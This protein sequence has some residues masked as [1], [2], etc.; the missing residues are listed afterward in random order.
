MVKNFFKNGRDF[1]TSRQTSILSAAFAIMV[2]TLLSKILGLVKDRVLTTYFPSPGLELDVYFAASKF[3]EALLLVFV[4]GAISTAFV[5]VFTDYLREKRLVAWEMAFSAMTAV[6]FLFSVLVV[7][8]IIVAPF[9]P[10]IL[11]PGLSGKNDAYVLMVR[12]LRLMFVS[13]IVFVASGFL[14]GVLHSFRRFVIPALAPVFYN[15]GVIGGIVFLSGRLGIDAAAWGML[16]GAVFHFLVQLP[17][18]ILIFKARRR[19]NLKLGFWHPGIMRVAKMSLPR[20]LGVLFAQTNDIVSLAL[21]SLVSLGA[22]TS[23]S[24]GGHLALAPVSLFGA[25]IGQATLPTLSSAVS[26]GKIRVFA[27]TLMVSL[28]QIIFL[29][30]GASVV[31]AVLKVPLVRLVFGASRFDW[32]ATVE[33]ARVV[34]GF[35]VGLFARAAVELLNRGFYAFEDSLTPLKVNIGSALVNIFLSGVLVLG[36]GLP[37]WGLAIAF[38]TAA[39]LNFLVIFWWLHQKV[40]FDLFR[41]GEFC[42][43]V[44]IASSLAG[45]SIYIPLKLLDKLVID[46]TRVVGLILLTGVVGTIGFSVYVFLTWLLKIEEAYMILRVFEKVRVSWKKLSAMPESAVAPPVSSEGQHLG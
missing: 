35:S 30:A 43:K 26:S 16:L 2:L 27:K 40:G 46:T 8:L 28:K 29:V 37:V 3:P 1:L 33:T 5:P 24:L 11:A 20:S 39:V 34:A 18:T 45:I 42:F 25:A 22:I 13:Q 21:A 7:L 23:F 15:L 44:F 41:F 4:G 31:L 19:N 36:F 10:P 12:L 9:L 6:T 32:L 38:S 17:L 14:T